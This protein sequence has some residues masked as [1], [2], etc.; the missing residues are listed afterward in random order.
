MRTAASRAGL[1]VP[2]QTPALPTP[3][4][5]RARCHYRQVL[6]PAGTPS[7]SQDPEQLG[8]GTK[9]CTS[10]GA[11]GTS[12]DGELVAQQ[13]VLEHEILARAH[14]DQHGREQEPEEFEH[15]LRI[16]DLARLR[17]C[18]LTG[19][20]EPSYDT[21][22]QII[23]QLPAGWSRWRTKGRRCT[24][25]DSISSIGARRVGP[26]R[27]GKQITRPSTC[28]CST[29]TIGRFDLG[30]RSS[31]TTTAEQWLATR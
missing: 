28:G 10:S 26:T 18:R 31:S 22:H 27:C 15:T 14:Q 30:S 12:Q 21:V 1:P 19:W 29:N 11:S 2:E 9:A 23:R 3:T 8:S 4:H 6:A 13:P 24:P 5:D 7:A 16:A 25:T 20:P 17:F